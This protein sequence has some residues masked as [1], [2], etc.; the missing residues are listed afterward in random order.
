MGVSRRDF[1]KL[2][3]AIAGASTLGLPPLIASAEDG[4]GITWPAGQALPRF[5][6]PLHLDAADI[7]TLSNDE[8]TTLMTLQGVVNRSRPRLYWM[9]QGDGT[10][11][12]W[13]NTVQVPH[14]IATDPWSLVA[15][16]AHEAAGVITYDATV[17]DTVNVATTMA[18]LQGAVIASPDLA[19]KLSGAPYNLRVLDDLRGRFTGKLD[20][21]NWALQNLW[22][23]CSHRLL[24]AV[25]GMTSVQAPGVQ[26]TQLLDQTTHVHD[27]SNRNTYTADL[28]SLLGG[29]AVY[30]RFRDSFSNDGWGPSVLHVTVTAD[31][32]PIADFQPT[33]AGEAPFVFDLDN[34]SIAG[35]G[36]RFADGGSSFVYRFNPPAGTRTLTLSVLMWGQYLVDATNTAPTLQEGFPNFRDYIV[37]TKAFVFWLDP[38][39][40]DEAALFETI[41]SGAEPDTPYL[42][43]FVGGHEA[44]GVTLCSRHGVPVLAADFFNN[45]TVFSGIPGAIRAEQPQVTT[46]G[47]ENKVY[48]TF[49]MSEGDNIQY[50]EH[51]M[52][53]LWDDPGR[54][55]TPLNWSVDPLLID[56]A[57][58]MLSHYQ[59]TQ[60][61]NDLLVAGPSGAGYTY[62][63]DWPGSTVDAFTRRSGRYMQRSG[64]T[65]IY[66]LNRVNGTDIPLSD[67]AALSYVANI[68]KLPGL[69]YNWE[70]TSQVTVAAG[71]LPVVTQ[72]GIG[73][74]GEGQTVLAN[75]ITTWDGKSPLFV[76]IGVLSW[77]LGPSDV[78]TLA[79]SLDH[80]TYSVVR[81]DVFFN[82][83]RQSLGL[84]VE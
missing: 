35:G 50:D 75:A 76:A 56:I 40:A 41:L 43:W 64:M 27:G 7:S 4:A 8:Q 25:G 61:P 16:Y 51:K 37:A 73:S 11:L 62:P 78:N 46:P 69:L 3:G 79:G 81:G 24:T 21:Y 5:A 42:G 32:T 54:G 55:K 67:N 59:R 9:L 1:L 68:P 14:T 47:L 58:S 82:L 39:V 71:P 52:R 18:G 20:A 57:P 19:T 36:W 6:P 48:V 38:L 22:P 29:S 12:T 2:S 53:L 66:A 72:R 60:T 23:S 83:L 80:T 63:S 31:G 44:E 17:P 70:S 13:M 65:L 30:V 45:G 74:L 28:S 77:N 33:T 10:D 15:K 26:W 34:S 84:K 49:T